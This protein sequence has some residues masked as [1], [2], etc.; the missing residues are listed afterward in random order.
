MNVT[1]NTTV[2][3]VTTQ[4]VSTDGS[5]Q[6]YSIKDA[7]NTSKPTGALVTGDQ[8]VVTAADGTTNVP[9]TIDVARA[10]SNNTSI[11]LNSSHAKL[12][13]VNAASVVIVAGATVADLLT[14]IV[15]TD[16]SPQNYVVTDSGNT[17]KVS[18]DVL[19]TGDILKVTAADGVAHKDYLIAFPTTNLQLNT[20][21]TTVIVVNNAD[22]R[23]ATSGTTT[24]ITTIAG[25]LKSTDGTIQTYSTTNATGTAKTTGNAVN[26][27]KLVV[28]AADGTTTATYTIAIAASA[29]S[30]YAQVKTASH[31]HVATLYNSDRTILAYTGITA[32]N[33]L[34]E[35][36]SSDAT[37]QSYS[38]MDAVYA[39]K[40]GNALLQTGD[41]L[42]VTPQDGLSSPS[43][44][45]INLVD[46]VHD[47]YAANPDITITTSNSNTINMG[48]D[49]TAGNHDR[50]SAV[51]NSHLQVNFTA[52]N[53]YIEFQIN[54]SVAGTYNVLF[55]SKKSN[56]GRNTMQLSVDGTNVGSAVNEV[57]ANQGMY[58]TNIGSV[59]LTAGSHMFRFKVAGSAS[60]QSFDFIA[61]TKTN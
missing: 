8:L 35:I 7:G 41:L 6:G 48:N 44:Y 38:V 21:N 15:S 32:A 52:A 49:D 11:A 5:T 4:V 2:A 26:G 39:V 57:T 27:D 29:S 31:P 3:H 13:A 58:S 20:G 25:Q 47:L 43:F 24:V 53:Q 61:L 10:L 16:V 51:N 1:S 42:K 28:K 23:I 45:T 34:A 9:Y 55:G 17:P 14:Q 46:V 40:T 36:E 22:R 33:L 12:Y 54:V 19:V 56:S 50:N 60:G 59:N 30:T 18:T 37:N